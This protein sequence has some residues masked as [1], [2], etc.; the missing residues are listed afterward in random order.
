MNVECK[1]IEK[2]LAGLE[3]SAVPGGLFERIES[4]AA[5]GRFGSEVIDEGAKVVPFPADS[6]RVTRMPAPKFNWTRM[7]VAAVAVLGAVIAWVMPDSHDRTATSGGGTIPAASFTPDIARSGVGDVRDEGV[8]WTGGQPL[9]KV[10]VIYRDR[11]ILR[12]ARGELMEVEM[13]RTEV[14]LVPERVD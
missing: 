9:R 5:A 2:M 12:N 7:A 14:V 11:V 3:P 6:R 13:P 10:R 4:E 1:Q 8:V